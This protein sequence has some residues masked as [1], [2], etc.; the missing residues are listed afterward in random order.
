MLCIYGIGYIL[1]L[2]SARKYKFHGITSMTEKVVIKHVKY[3][4]QFL[5]TLKTENNRTL[6]TF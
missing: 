1:L 6:G 5:G 2:F 4:V 3:S